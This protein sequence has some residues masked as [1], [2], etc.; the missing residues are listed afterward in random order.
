MGKQAAEILWKMMAEKKAGNPYQV[1]LPTKL[2]IR[3]SSGQLIK[4]TTH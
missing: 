1:I 3:E 4:A 2:V